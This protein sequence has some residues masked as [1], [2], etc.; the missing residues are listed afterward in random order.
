MK[1]FISADIEGV[2]GI[3]S[4]SEAT[5]S[6][7]SYREFQQQMTL[8]VAAACDGAIAAGATDILVKDA[9]GGA[10]NLIAAELPAPTRVV[11]GWSGDPMAMVQELD[12]TFSCAMF[13]GYHARAGA[14]GNPLAHTLSSAKLHR[15]FI[16]D[17]PASEFYI[18]YL[19]AGLK[20]V[21]VIMLSGDADI[22]DEVNETDPA[23]VTT[24]TK[25]ANGASTVSIHPQQAIEAIR[26]GSEQAVRDHAHVS[27]ATVPDH[28][29]LKIVYKD[30]TNAF[31]RAQYPGARLTDPYTVEWRSDDY[32]EVMR[33]LIFLV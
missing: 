31:Y 32:Y 21:P 17:R 19:A 25:F 24:A 26:T 4:W 16:N 2:A 15:I 29:T 33:A 9:H 28:T 23:I 10:D 14:G 6:H 8:E 1:V 12:E 27:P 22:C 5:R 7:A 30:Q 18:H 11:R 13:I 20:S 3:T